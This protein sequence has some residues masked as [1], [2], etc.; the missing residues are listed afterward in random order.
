MNTHK[1]YS[2]PESDPNTENFIR[3]I[4]EENE[5]NRFGIKIEPGDI[6]LDCGSN[7]GIFTDY[8]LDMGAQKVYSYEANEE[9]FEHYKK[10]IISNQVIPTLWIVGHNNYDITK[11]KEQHNLNKIDF[12]KIDIEG[13]EWDF[14]KYMSVDELKFVKKW[15]I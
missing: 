12:A 4:Y 14:F 5:Y 7:V 6:V 11:I 2:A 1:I 15:A 3:E 8:A 13:A 10:N 9:T